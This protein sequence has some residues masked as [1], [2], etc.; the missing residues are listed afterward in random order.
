MVTTASTRFFDPLIANS[1]ASKEFPAR[2]AGDCDSAIGCAA[3]DGSGKDSGSAG[4]DGSDKN[5]GSPIGCA[6]F[7]T[8]SMVDCESI[9]DDTTNAGWL[10]DV[11]RRFSIADSS[12]VEAE[13]RASEADRSPKSGA[14]VFETRVARILDDVG[15]ADSV[16]AIET[17]IGPAADGGAIAADNAD[18]L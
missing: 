16:P 10:S 8:E 17:E 7:H 9:A 6:S 2:P 11:G 3:D 12:N 18:A 14:D 13:V 1:N 4:N 5:E 15:D